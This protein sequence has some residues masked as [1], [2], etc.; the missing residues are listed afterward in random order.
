[1]KEKQCLKTAKREDITKEGSQASP[2]RLIGLMIL[3][4]LA[5][6]SAWLQGKITKL[7]GQL[8]YVF[9]P[10]E[11][12]R[13]RRKPSNFWVGLY[14]ENWLIVFDSSQQW[15]ESLLS[16]VRN[17][18]SFYLRKMRAIKLIGQRL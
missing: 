15:V 11:T 6:T 7:Q 4:A 2:D 17:K 10:Q 8:K 12:G 14:R 9:C 18:K 1:M 5:M 3:R 13:S 16:F